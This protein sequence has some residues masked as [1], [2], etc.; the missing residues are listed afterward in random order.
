VEPLTIRKGTRVG[1]IEGLHDSDVVPIRTALTQPCTK[2]TPQ[3]EQLLHGLVQET[4]LPGHLQKEL[5]AVLKKH[6]EAFAKNKS[7]LGRTRKIQHRIQTQSSPP[8]NQRVRRLAPNKYAEA[9]KQ[10][11]EML[12]KDVIQPSQSA[13]ASPVVLVTK[14]DSTFRFC[15]DYRKLNTATVKDARPVPQIDD[16]LDMLS[17]CQWFSTLDLI[18]GYWQVEVA[19]EDR[20]KTAFCTP[21]GLYEYNVMPFGL[22]NAPA[23][24]QRLMN[25][26]LAGR[27]DSCLVYLDDIIIIR[28]T[29]EEHLCNLEKVLECLK[30]AGLKVHPKKCQLCRERVTFLGHVV[31]R[32]GVTTDPQKTEVVNQWPVPTCVKEV[33]SF[34]GLANYYRRFVK[35][36]ATIA[37]PLHKLTQKQSQ[38]DWTEECQRSFEQ[39]KT[40]LTSA[41]LLVF[42]NFTK[43]FILDTD[44]SN[45]GIGAVLSQ[46]DEQG[47][48][49]VVA[50]ASRVLSKP[51]RNYCVTRKEL[52]AAVYFI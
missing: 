19:P 38:F 21:W 15:I 45:S 10:V 43:K 7:D 50:Y 5:L 12:E 23:T 40:K 52:L 32:E 49:R 29:F 30:S 4:K 51:E 2:P 26:I 6:G 41:P 25:T 3:L 1:V 11:Q 46:M 44:A 9:Q 22:C 17:G 14:K 48:E 37:S 13:W 35:D 47:C 16:T 27:W 8:I 24:F 31:S 42:P 33:Q 28:R 36:F 34:L 39:L 20:S 18:S